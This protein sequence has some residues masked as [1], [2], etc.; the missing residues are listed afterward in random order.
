MPLTPRAGR[1]SV[2]V[3]VALRIRLRAAAPPFGGLSLTDPAP[4][5]I[6]ALSGLIAVAFFGKG[7]VK[8]VFPSRA[9]ARACAIKVL[10][11]MKFTTGRPKPR[12]AKPLPVMVKLAGGVATSIELGGRPLTPGPGPV[13]VTVT[14]ALSIRLKVGALPVCAQ[15]WAWTGPADSPGIFF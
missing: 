13:S 9:V 7:T 4:A 10:P 14:A 2:T 1:A 8:V 5:E 3:R 12:F 15:T 11:R 6:Q